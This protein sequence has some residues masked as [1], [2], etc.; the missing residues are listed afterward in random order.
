M[1]SSRA[2]GKPD[3]RRDPES[4]TLTQL[5][6]ELAQRDADVEELT[7]EVLRVV[8]LNGHA[9]LRDALEALRRRPDIES[10]DIDRRVLAALTF[11]EALP[12]WTASRPRNDRSNPVVRPAYPERRRRRGDAPQ[13]PPTP[14]TS[15]IVTV[16]TARMDRSTDPAG[17]H[18]VSALWH[19]APSVS[20][21]HG[22]TT[23][24]VRVQA[25]SHERAR[26]TIGMTLLQEGVDSAVFDIDAQP[27]NA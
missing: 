25:D 22:R 1:D 20:V 4:S 26:V 21:D 18:L 12:L 24:R 9:T 19:L 11:I 3:P 15:W 5:V 8:G 10:T 16:S 17:I 23:L 6:R 14:A 7:A 27:D 13:P 2:T